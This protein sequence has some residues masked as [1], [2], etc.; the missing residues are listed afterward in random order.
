MSST[1]AWLDTSREE[2][3]R[4]RE[5]LSLFSQT[6][7]RDELGIGQI[8]DAFSELLFPGTSTLHTRARYLLF[9]PWCYR[10]AARRGSASREVDRAER[11]LIAALQTAGG[12]EGLIGGRRGVAVK[13]LPSTIY[14]TA[15][16]RFGIR[17]DHAAV[18]GRIGLR[19]G[20]GE[21]IDRAASP[22]HPLLPD[23]PPGFPHTVPGGFVMS[24]AEASWL[25]ERV[26]SSVPGS[27]LAHL[28]THSRPPL[29]DSPTPWAEPTCRDAPDE[30]AEV[31]HHAE[32]FSFAMH[33]AALLYNLLLAR[34]YEANGFTKVDNPVE[35]YRDLLA[36]WTQQCAA[37]S[38]VRGWD[39]RRMWDLVLPQ[40]PRISP[41]TRSFVDTWLDACRVPETVPTSPELA[42]LIENRERWQK[43]NQ[44]RLVNDELLRR[45]A[46]AAGTR[47]LTYRWTQARA[48]V[49]DIRAGLEGGARVA[50]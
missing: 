42:T 4:I 25:R 7:S 13:N 9:V 11:Q 18:E 35:T 47:R 39:R 14:S 23:A 44:A 28:L 31:L 27:M 30:L 19:D 46:G 41:I 2:Q 20:E 49:R 3:R 21:L 6:D 10:E 43:R 8:R 26:I 40:N 37:D 24:E 34:R 17:G 36:V 29:P 33:G 32:L 1:V 50:T 15:L 45:W 48:L 22:W 38:R 5:L 12:T 16:D